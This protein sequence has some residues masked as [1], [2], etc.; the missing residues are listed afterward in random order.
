MIDVLKLPLNLGPVLA[1]LTA[2]VFM[3]S[4]KLVALRTVFQALL[5]GV[6]MAVAG[7]FLNGWLADYFVLTKDALVRY[8]VP[9]TE[10][11]LKALFVIFM[12][13]T[14]RV[15]FLVDAAIL[16]FAVGAGFALVENVY[17]LNELDL[18]FGHWIVRGFGTAIMH[19]STTAI[20][21]L[22]SKNLA[23]QYPAGSFL[24]FIPG[25]LLGMVIHSF[26]NHFFFDPLLGA[27][28]FLITMP[29]VLITV[30]ER[31]EHATR[32][33]LGTGFDSD[34]ELLEVVT[35][36]AIDDSRVGQYLESLKSKFPGVV[37]GDMLCLLTLHLELSVR[38]KGILMAREAGIKLEPDEEVK[39]NLKELKFLEASVGKTGR[40]ALA[41]FLNMSSRELWQ[42]YMLGK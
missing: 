14:K 8:I 17:Y 10:E 31:S 36:G 28:I 19:G 16:G 32:N 15:G 20:L 34:I 35:T 33:W 41:P 39:A 4:F 21:G 3:D 25:L 30:F 6:S 18:E 23:D 24:V 37:V 22:L 2:L 29:L 7:Y 1:F 13:S 12:I 27:A 9:L 40:M 42:L 11:P 26:H 38:A 5:W